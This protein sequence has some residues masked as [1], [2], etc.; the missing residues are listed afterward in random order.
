MAVSP[1]TGS[2]LK[3]NFFDRNRDGQ[4]DAADLITVTGENN[5]VPVSAIRFDGMPSE[6]VF[7][8]DRMVVGLAD[9]RIAN[10]EV[11]LNVLRGRV[12]WRE[13]LNQ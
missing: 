11:D 3:Y 10:V 7:F 13:L 6:P 4:I 12:S 8:E 9:T 2:R 1:Y 5:P